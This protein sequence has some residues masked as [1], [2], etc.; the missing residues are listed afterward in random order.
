MQAPFPSDHKDVLKVS[1]ACL[2]HNSQVSLL[3]YPGKE[4]AGLGWW[5]NNV[6]ACMQEQ[7]LEATR[8]LDPQLTAPL[9]PSLPIWVSLGGRASSEHISC[10]QRAVYKFCFGACPQ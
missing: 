5:V 8:G 6:R 7:E 3:D 10:G 9:V 2:S 4:T 1:F